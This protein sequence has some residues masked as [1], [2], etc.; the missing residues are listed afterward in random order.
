VST[1]APSASARAARLAAIERRDELALECAGQRQ[2]AY[3]PQVG[4]LVPHEP[5]EHYPY[6][7]LVFLP[8]D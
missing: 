8:R 1:D 7:N 2:R 6:A 5:R 3:E 4:S